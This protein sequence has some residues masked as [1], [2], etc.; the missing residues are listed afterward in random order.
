GVVLIGGD[1]GIGKSTLLLQAADKLAAKGLRVLY[2]SGEESAWQIRLRARRLG[3]ESGELYVLAETNLDAI[4]QQTGELQP[5]LVIVDSIQMLYDSAIPSAPGSVAQVRE[6]A[7]TLIHQA[8]SSSVPIV[9]IGHVTKEGNIAGPRTLEHMVDTVLYFEGDKHHNFRILRAVKNRFGA[10]SEIG[11]FEMGNGGL[12][13]VLNPSQA[14]LEEYDSQRAGAAICPT[15]EGTRVLLVEIQALVAPA[16]AM[17]S[18]RR[19]VSG[20]DHNRA[21][22]LLAVLERRAGMPLSRHEAYLNIAG[23]ITVEEPAADLATCFAIAS[24]M[25]EQRLPPA[26]V[27]IGEVGLGGEVR[28]VN[29]LQARLDEAAKLGFEQAVIPKVRGKLTTPKGMKLVSVTD[30]AQALAKFYLVKP[31]GKPPQQENQADDC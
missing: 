5:A 15:V 4:R 14:L 22:M 26:T 19:R 2:I 31:R 13:E 11:I 17:S 28:S 1:P 12:A 29:M 21:S 9:L 24:S 16:P 23:G 3:C 7:A 10:T 20:L 6:C 18:P 27:F 8:K 25:T 30:V